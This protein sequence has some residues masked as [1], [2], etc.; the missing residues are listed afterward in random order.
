MKSIWKY[1]LQI[2]D[3]Q[4]LYLPYG[5][6]LLCIQSQK[7]FNA[8]GIPFE[9]PCIWALVTTD[10][11]LNTVDEFKIYT[12]VTGHP[13]PELSSNVFYLG[14]YQLMEGLQVYHVFVERT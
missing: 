9:V 3:I 11:I 10:N 2:A 8:V 1:K 7:D 14:T 6:E 5:S 4:T 13:I 12:F